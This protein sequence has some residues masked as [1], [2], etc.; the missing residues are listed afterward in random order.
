MLAQI[1]TKK[2]IINFRNQTSEINILASR[3]RKQRFICMKKNMVQALFDD[4]C[5][6]KLSFIT[7]FIFAASPFERVT[8][9]ENIL[10]LKLLGLTR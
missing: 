1:M 8:H 7:R 6:K 5:Q 4:Y 10:L 9:L 3:F 2:N